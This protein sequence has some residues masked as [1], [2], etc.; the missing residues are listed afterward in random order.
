M[1]DAQKLQISHIISKVLLF[2][3]G[4]TF[5]LFP[6]FFSTLTTDPFTLPKEALLAF[7]VLL[8]L[9]LWGAKMLLDKQVKLRRT[10]FDIPVLLFGAALLLSSLFAVNRTDSLIAIIPVMFAILSYFVVINIVREKRGLLFLTLSLVTGGVL[11]GIITTLNHVK[12]YLLPISQ[13]HTTSFSPLG[14]YFDLGLYLV[15]LAPLIIMYILPSIKRKI[16]GQTIAFGV[17]GILVLFALLVTGNE[18]LGTQKPLIL[19]FQTGFQTAFAA[20]SQD[21]GRVA[22]GFFFG[23]GYGNYATVFS[24]FK[25]VTIN[26]DPN[27]WATPFATSSSYVLELLATT[28]I[29]GILAYLFFIIRFVTP[30]SEKAKN[31]AYFS[32]VLV[33]LLSFLIP[34]SF[35]EVSLFFFLLSIFALRQAEMQPGQ[36][37]EMEL[38]IVALRKGVLNFAMADETSRRGSSPITHLLAF[39]FLLLLVLV[40]GFYSGSFVLSDAL[41]QNSLV[42][43]NQNSGTLT[44]KYQTQA[45]T[46]FPYR[47]AYYRIFSQTNVA[48]ANSLLSLSASS[49]SSPSAQVQQTAL[50][51]VQQSITA[52]KQATT[53]SP[54]D[55]LAWQ[56]LASDYRSLI[57]VGQN[58]D[59]FAIAANQQA[60][61]LDPVNPQE[62]VALGGIY[63]QLGKYDNA[64]Q[65]FQTAISLKQDYANA[66]YNL[67]HAYEQ[68]NDTTDALAALQVVKQ[69]MSNDKTNAQKVDAEIKALEANAGT[70]DQTTTA[71][72]VK[73]VEKTQPLALPTTT[74]LPAQPTQI[75][76]A[77]P[78]PT[79]G[80]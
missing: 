34:F 58:A 52:A 44:Y 71:K 35:I 54:Q 22:Q 76:L 55:V 51:L 48:L 5:L 17:L 70:T 79:P 27:L 60:A 18:L 11:S 66:Y 45:I 50:T 25:P 26:A 36:Y 29:V 31:P 10:P 53:L 57:G 46:T 7:V 33:F 15:M 14:S 42:A 8:S 37:Y 6:V 21:N 69:L 64:I 80:K 61:Q 43:A 2:V 1:Q 68:K 74:E 19:P 13:T 9:L 78:T 59:S 65:A 39:A 73:P 49:K 23:S 4:L 47:S 20:I 41:F 16:T 56:N 3:W 63:Y 72:N 30:L 38:R 77:S 32:I 40:G 24:R 75:P 67:A 28:G 12:V 62:Y